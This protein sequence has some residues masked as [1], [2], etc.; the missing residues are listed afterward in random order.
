MINN[1]TKAS[2][3]KESKKTE[4]S[5][6]DFELDIDNDIISYLSSIISN[7]NVKHKILK[8]NNLID[9]SLYNTYIENEET[10]KLYETSS[11]K[12]NR[13]DHSEILTYINRNNSDCNKHNGIANYKHT[14]HINGNHIFDKNSDNMLVSHDK[15]YPFEYSSHEFIPS[16][17]PFL[18]NKNNNNFKI[19]IMNMLSNSDI[20]YN[21]KYKQNN[22]LFLCYDECNGE[23]CNICFKYKE[24]YMIEMQT[25]VNKNEP[26]KNDRIQLGKINKLNGNESNH[27]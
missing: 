11:E 9:D 16:C 24:N 17:N 10:D 20:F 15:K 6:T 25:S 4:P 14:E 5:F 12:K 21:N 13:N 26:F 1:V 27:E 7:K 22:V 19:N 18:K 3:V 23:T 2:I 8:I